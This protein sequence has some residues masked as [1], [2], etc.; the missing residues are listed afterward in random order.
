MATAPELAGTTGRYFYKLKEI[1]SNKGSYD[2]YIARALWERSET[3]TGF[4]YP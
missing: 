3:L 2:I 1:R 4:F